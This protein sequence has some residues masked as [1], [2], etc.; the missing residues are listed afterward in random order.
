MDS[1]NPLAAHLSDRA[2]KHEYQA[3][4]KKESC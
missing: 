2:P 1:N 4:R 3:E